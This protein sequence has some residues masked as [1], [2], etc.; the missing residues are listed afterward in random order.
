ML[1]IKLSVAFIMFLQGLEI[2]MRVC[3][4]INA[5]SLSEGKKW[6]LLKKSKLLE[7]T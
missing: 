5:I 6:I 2:F 1:I 7:L 3:Y 4:N